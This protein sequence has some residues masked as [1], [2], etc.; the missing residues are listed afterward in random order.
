MDPLLGQ[1]QPPYPSS[2]LKCCPPIWAECVCVCVCVCVCWGCVKCVCMI[3]VFVCV[4]VCVCLCVFLGCMECVCMIAV[5]VC[6]CVRVGVW[7]VCLCVRG[8]VCVF[9]K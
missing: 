4:C 6:V 3:A 5:C 1:A 9:I 8:R 7:C 2:F